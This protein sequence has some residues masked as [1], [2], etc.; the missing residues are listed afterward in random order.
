LYVVEVPKSTYAW[1][2]PGYAEGREHRRIDD[3]YQRGGPSW[4]TYH[5]KDTAKGP[6]VWR[7]RSVRVVLH[8]GKDRSEKGLLIVV[9]P[10][11]GETKYFLSNAP[12]HIATETLLTVAFTR[13]R[14]ERNFEDS[15][16]EVGLDHFEV[17]R[18]RALQRHL[19]LSMVS[20][21]FLVKTS[22]KLKVT[23]SENWTV[24]QTR[25]VVDT[26]VDQEMVPEQR[27]RTLKI[28]LFK[29]TYWQR[30]AKVAERGH[31][32]RRL[33]EL[34]AAGIHVESLPRCPSWPDGS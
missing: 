22:L 4:V 32:K 30:R 31:R 20:L 5:V 15:K 27:A 28:N 23:T 21:L 6:V 3:L 17:R 12:E 34:D 9:D 19:A 1:T 26:L 13:W 10:I 14:V 25:L 24:A 16:Q 11:T 2:R 33:R 18:Y 29:I 8:A 7:V